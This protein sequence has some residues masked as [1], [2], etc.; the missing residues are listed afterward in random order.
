MSKGTDAGKPAIADAPIKAAPAFTPGPLTVAWEEK[1]PFDLVTRDANGKEVWRE[2]AYCTSSAA[3]TL[4][5]HL[6]AVGF[7]GET[8]NECRAA[9][10]RQFADALLRAAAPEMFEALRYARRFLNDQDHDTA[11]VDAALLKATGGQS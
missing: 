6:W 9:L 2:A 8:V 3:R 1:R 11:F 4:E 5:D 7:R 10:Q